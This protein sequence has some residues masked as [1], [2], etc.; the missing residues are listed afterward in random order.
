MG[1]Q[2]EPILTFRTA[3]DWEAWL[4]REHA[5]FEGGVWLRLAKKG[6]TLQTHSYAEALDVALCWGWIDGQKRALDKE[7]FLQ[8]FTR[9]RPRSIW[10]KINCGKVEALVASGR[11]RPPGQRE[12]DAAKADGRWEAAYEGQRTATVPPDLAAALAADPKAKA[13]F[14]SLDG[15]NRYAILYRLQEAKRPE[16]RTRRLEKYLAMLAAGGKIH[17]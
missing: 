16:T 13:A 8:R 12:V 4:E 17:G 3:A 2:D 6:A 5:R 10:S 15:A 14:E 11:M 1:I 7:A 9:R